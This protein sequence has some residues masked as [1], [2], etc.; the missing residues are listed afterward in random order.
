ME[1]AEKARIE[2]EVDSEQK[3]AYLVRHFCESPGKW[4]VI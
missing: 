4:C 1:Y 3:V 2:G